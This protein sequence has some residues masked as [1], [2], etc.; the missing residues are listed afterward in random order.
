MGN[1]ARQA[2]KWRSK[3][4]RVA[5]LIIGDFNVL[6]SWPMERT[7]WIIAS[8]GFVCDPSGTRAASDMNCSSTGHGRSTSQSWSW[9][10]MGLPNSRDNNLLRLENRTLQRFKHRQHTYPMR[11]FPTKAVSSFQLRP[12]AKGQIPC[13]GQYPGRF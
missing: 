11:R 1:V 5:A 12:R 3:I 13:A 2:L 9:I 7:T 6:V 10:E 8:R 4:S